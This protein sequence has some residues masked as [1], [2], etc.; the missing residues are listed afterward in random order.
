MNHHGGRAIGGHYTTFVYHPGVHGWIHLDDS[1]VKSVNLSQVLKLDH[2]RVPYLLYYRRVD[3][4]PWY[5]KKTFILSA[6]HRFWILG[7]WTCFACWD[8]CFVLWMK[9]RWMNIT[10]SYSEKK[11][12]LQW[13]F[14]EWISTS[15]KALQVGC[16]TY[17]LRIW[18][19]PV[20]LNAYFLLCFALLL[21]LGL[22][23]YC[24]AKAWVWF[25]SK[26]KTQEYSHIVLFIPFV[27]KKKR[28]TI[29]LLRFVCLFVDVFVCNKQKTAG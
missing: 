2:P 18:S 6:F 19:L 28:Y 17:N 25:L 3:I 16:A 11:T 29:L 26:V 9:L 27:K 1:G 7:D 10:Y 21:L 13:Q 5:H 4:T 15:L 23:A 20:T 8:A 22:I 24:R 12:Y 14:H